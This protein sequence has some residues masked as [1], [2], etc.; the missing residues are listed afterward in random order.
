M[1]AE[2]HVGCP[3]PGLHVRGESASAESSGKAGG[4]AVADMGGGAY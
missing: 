3:I 2:V 1:Y 4:V